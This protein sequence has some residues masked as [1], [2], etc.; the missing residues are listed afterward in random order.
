VA[1]VSKVRSRFEALASL[2]NT[3]P[4]ERGADADSRSQPD[5]LIPTLRRRSR[6]AP[7][8]RFAPGPEGKNT[9]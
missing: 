2:P 5:G 6:I 4:D 8:T 9:I 3:R 7:I 1:I